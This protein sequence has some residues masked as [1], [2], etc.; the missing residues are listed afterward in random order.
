MK[1][2]ASIALSSLQ[3][4]VWWT[5]LHACAT[6]ALRGGWPPFMH[7]YALGGFLPVY[8]PQPYS[9]SLSRPVSAISGSGS[10]TTDKG[11]GTEF[12]DSESGGSSLG[13]L[14]CRICI[15]GALTCGPVGGKLVLWLGMG[16]WMTFSFSSSAR[17]VRFV[18]SSVVL[19]SLKIMFHLTMTDFLSG[20]Y[21]Q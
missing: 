8:H 6:F 21:M 17:T 13:L 2:V 4:V 14:G 7:L 15:C 19:F 12:D 10:S 5:E 3:L 9:S 1:W 16:A 18:S 11:N 20:Q